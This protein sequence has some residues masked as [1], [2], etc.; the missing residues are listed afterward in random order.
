MEAVSFRMIWGR[1]KCIISIRFSMYGYKIIW[2][3]K[4]QFNTSDC[5]ILEI[6]NWDEYMVL[7]ILLR[8]RIF[9]TID[10][11]QNNH[12]KTSKTSSRWAVISVNKTISNINSTTFCTHIGCYVPAAQSQFCQQKHIF[13]WFV[14]ISLYSY[15][16]IYIYNGILVS[17]LIFYMKLLGF[18]FSTLNGSKKN[19][20]EISLSNDIRCYRNVCYRVLGVVILILLLMSYYFWCPNLTLYISYSMVH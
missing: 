5:Q 3:K 14:H 10:G 7:N 4:L 9:I 15:S 12:K 8:D 18:G 17:I 16:Y 1:K 2:K 6:W 13:C 19:Y 11:L 20:I